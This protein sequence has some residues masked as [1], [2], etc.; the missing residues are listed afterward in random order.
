MLMTPPTPTP[1]SPSIT[2]EQSDG[3]S[4]R[5]WQGRQWNLLR[6]E[7]FSRELLSVFNRRGEQV[8]QQNPDR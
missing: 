1:P 4:L 5:S 6:W 7:F 2:T 8:A 3:H